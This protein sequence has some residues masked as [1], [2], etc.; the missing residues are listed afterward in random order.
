MAI[1]PYTM[2]NFQ[3]ASLYLIENNTTADEIKIDIG[4]DIYFRFPLN[5]PNSAASSIKIKLII[6]RDKII[7]LFRFFSIEI[8]SM[9]FYKVYLVKIPYSKNDIPSN[10][11][12]K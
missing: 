5:N 6:N 1:I 7:L 11:I 8:G 2:N 10:K 4:P 12:I 9:I 3:D